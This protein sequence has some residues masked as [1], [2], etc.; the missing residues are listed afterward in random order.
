[1]ICTILG[2]GGSNGVPEIGCKCHVCSSTDPKNKRLRSSI[3]IESST[4]S[5]LVDTSPDL[6]QQALT[7]DITKVD[8]ILYTHPHGDHCHGIDDIKHFCYKNQPIEAFTDEYTAEKLTTIF[9]YMFKQLTPWH[10][11]RIKMNTIKSPFAIGDI[12]VRSFHQSH[13]NIKSLGFRFG[14][15]GYSTDFDHLDENAIE[16]LKGIKIWIIDCLRY[17][18]SPTHSHLEKSLNFIER[19]KPELAI[20]THMSHSIEYNEINAMLPKNIVAGFDGM[21]IKFNS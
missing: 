20:L 19:V 17:Q 6:R 12:Q 5:I 18:S 11:A 10:P 15:L 2:C 1:M 13:G 4:T 14:E 7:N 3:H 8:A 21:K 9:P 16:A